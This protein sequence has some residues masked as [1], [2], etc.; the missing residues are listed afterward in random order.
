MEYAILATLIAAAAL[1]GVIVLF[2]A[3]FF[4]LDIA[5]L[6]LSGRGKMAGEAAPDYQQQ[7][8]EGIEQAGRYTKEFSDA[9]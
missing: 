2:R 4:G 7:T 8:S 6:G 9:R 5:G 1:I 3:I